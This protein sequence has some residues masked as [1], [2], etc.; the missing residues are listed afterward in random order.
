MSWNSTQRHCQFQQQNFGSHVQKMLLPSLKSNTA[1]QKT[2]WE[3]SGIYWQTQQITESLRKN[4]QQNQKTPIQQGLFPAPGE[5]S[6][7]SPIGWRPY[8]TY[9]PNWPVIRS[10]IWPQLADDHILHTSQISWWPDLT[11]GQVGR[12]LDFAFVPKWPVI[13]SYIW[14]RL[15]GDLILHVSQICQWPNLTF[16]PNWPVTRFYIWPQCVGDKILHIFPQIAGDQIFHMSPIGRWPDLTYIS[17]W[18]VTISYKWPQLAD[19]H[20][21]HMAPNV[22][23]SCWPLLINS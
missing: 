5:T 14:P 17:N 11:Y 22:W 16:V 6:N 18:R 21:L 2:E 10:Y 8:I 4:P 23:L 1:K 12:W 19:D 20:I 13:R 7:T 15:A 3:Q 9:V